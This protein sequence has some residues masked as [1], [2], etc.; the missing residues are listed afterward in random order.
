MEALGVAQFA[1]GEPN[2]AIATLK[3]ASQLRPDNAQTLLVLADL[4]TR[5][6]DWD[7]AI[8]SMRS[9]V[10]LQ[11]RSSPVWLAFA[12]V[13][14]EAGRLPAGTDEAR[15]LQKQYPDRATG[16]GLE[17][18][19]YARQKK[20]PE[21]VV[22]YRTAFARQPD[23]PVVLRLLALLEAAGKGDEVQ[24]VAQRWIRDHP[25][26]VPV[27]AYLGEVAMR[28]GDYKAAAQQLRN[29]LEFEPYNVIVV[30]NLAWVLGE[31]GDQSALEYAAKAYALAPNVAGINNTYGWL[32]VQKGDTVRGIELLRRAVELAPNDANKRVILARALVKAGDKSE[33]KKELAELSKDNVPTATRAE[34]EKMLKDL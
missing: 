4:Q 8:Q 3:Q 17:G 20:W 9:A 33:A 13:Y 1:S 31:M 32:L 29:A 25:R 10:D 2:Q 12:A 34:I 26:D 18:E 14:D 7:G 22:A 5:V 6:K 23:A 21:A 16:F 19:L 30:N 15:R 24:S 27:R 28:R 11:P